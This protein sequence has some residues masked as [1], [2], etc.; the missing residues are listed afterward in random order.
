MPRATRREAAPLPEA[1]ATI[2]RIKSGYSTLRSSISIAASTMSLLVSL[3][4]LDHIRQFLRA[5]H[6]VHE[7]F[8]LSAALRRRQPCTCTCVPV[9]DA[10]RVDFMYRAIVDGDIHAVGHFVRH[11][12]ALTLESF[13]NSTP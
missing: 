2:A 9:I 7:D 5:E 8:P 3:Q 10:D 12:R 13:F 4:R 11:F 6:P 1:L